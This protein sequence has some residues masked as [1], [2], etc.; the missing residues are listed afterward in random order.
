MLLEL[1]SLPTYEIS[2]LPERIFLA[3]IKGI[4]SYV[5]NLSLL[6]FSLFLVVVI[7]VH[8]NPLTRQKAAV[9]QGFILLIFGLEVSFVNF[10]ALV[11][12]FTSGIDEEELKLIITLKAMLVAFSFDYSRAPHGRYYGN[13]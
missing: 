8:T 3:T 6:D 7:L 5:I 4:L 2:P 11:R 12:H 13:T 9:F 1:P 10:Y